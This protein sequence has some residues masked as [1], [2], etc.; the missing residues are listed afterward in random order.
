MTDD[1]FVDLDGQRFFVRRSGPSSARPV[2]LLHGFPEYS[3][4]WTE[5]MSH[6]PDHRLLAPDQRGYGQSWAPGAVSDYKTRALVSDMAALI[7]GHGHSPMV[8]VGH[9]W[10]AAV[11]YALAI[12]HP[13]LVSHLIILNGVHP[14]CF[15]A[16]L[17]SG[18]A[19]SSASAYIDWLRAPGSEEILAADGHARLLSLF[20]ANMDM[21]WLSGDRL[22][23]YRAAWSRPGRLASMI[24]WYRASPL[25]VAL[26]GQP[27]DL[28][29]PP[30]SAL[31]ITMPHLVIW[32]DADTALLPESLVGLDR[33]APDLTIETIAGADHW[34]HHTH[35][36]LV[37]RH[38]TSWL[39]TRP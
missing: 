16:A 25:Q 6:M 24:N 13:E 18:G 9:D 39:A 5:L 28:P 7:R 26:P 35:A 27:I 34:L 22:A 1:T 30:V 20:S 36:P 10:G 2:L 14:A 33:Y 8:V 29:P 32:G 19:Q 15:Q 3:G 17:A 23:D 37:A 38:I 12:R 11:A 4:A 31:R 21:S